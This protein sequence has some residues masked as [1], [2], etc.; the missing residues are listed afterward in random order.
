LK[1]L[2]QFTVWGKTETRLRAEERWT[3]IIQKKPKPNFREKDRSKLTNGGERRTKLREKGD[4]T[5]RTVK[6]SN[7][8]RIKLKQRA[9]DCN[10]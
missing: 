9:D 6:H 5:G 8:E 3:K 7:R 4:M 2:D 1:A 10:Y